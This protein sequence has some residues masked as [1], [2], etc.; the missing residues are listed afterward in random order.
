MSAFSL[1]H[2]P[3]VLGSSPISGSLLSGE[4]ASPS[5]SPPQLVL[6]P[7]SY[8]IIRDANT[9]VIK[10][11]MTCMQQKQITQESRKKISHLNI[12]KI[13]SGKLESETQVN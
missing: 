10:G 7:L 6:S 3:G 1:G 9:P 4:S 11:Q 8:S 12:T 13:H 2:D 5:P